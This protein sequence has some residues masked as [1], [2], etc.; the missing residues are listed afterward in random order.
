[1]V[2]PYI[3]EIIDDFKDIQNLK[4]HRIPKPDNPTLEEL[5]KSMEEIYRFNKI[6]NSKQI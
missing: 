4:R 3:D 2:L 1:M 5:L 6:I